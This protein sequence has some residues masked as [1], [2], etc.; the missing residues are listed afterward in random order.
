MLH[1]EKKLSLDDS[2]VKF[3]PGFRLY[4]TY[5][6]NNCTV[7]DLLCHRIGLQTFQGDFVNWGSNL[8]RTE[9]VAQLAKNKPV[10]GFRATYGYC[11]MGFAAAGEVI[12]AASGMTWDKFVHDKFFVALRM[13]RSSTTYEELLADKNKCTGHSYWQGKNIRV[14]ILTLG[15]VFDE[16]LHKGTSFAKNYS[17]KTMLGRMAQ[18]EDYDGSLLFLASDASSY[19]TGAN[20]VVDGGWTAW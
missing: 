5:T 12:L 15:G 11:N 3:I 9:I 17:K 19:M 8:T 1:L 7:R 13:N 6:T 2:V 14:N 10:F 4:E 16:K 18:K 20:L